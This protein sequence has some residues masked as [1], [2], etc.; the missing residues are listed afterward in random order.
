MLPSLL[1][2]AALTAPAAPVPK[3][4]VPNMTGPA[5]RI[6]AVKAEAGGTVWITAHVY[7]KQK[8]QHQFV[9]IE[10]G[11]QVVKQQ[12]VEQMT[13]NYVRKSIGDFGGKFV[14]AD[15]TSLTSEDAARRLHNGATLLITADGKPVDKGWLKAV[16]SDTIIMT[17]E[18][19]GEAHFVFGNDP[20]PLTASPRLVMLATD[21]KGDVRLP[22][23]PNAGNGNGQF[24]NEFNMRGRGGLRMA[25]ADIV[26]IDGFA[27][28][29]PVVTPTGTD[30]KKAL[31]D[32]K[33]EAYDVTGKLVQR[34]DA[35]NRLKAGGLILLAGDNRFPDANYL[36]AFREDLLVIVS[37]ELVFQ[38]GQ[39]NPFDRATLKPAAPA[40]G[41]PAVA[42]A[43]LVPLRQLNVQKIQIE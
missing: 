29:Q 41:Q 4:T 7:Q 30:G 20:Y 42:P 2:A 22:V 12:E 33:F 40:A 16:A 39:L 13:S 9:A 3:D 6:V 35:L 32:I 28:P 23:N 10:N 26:G 25:Q 43:Q 8:V 18:G 11:K 5:P 15:G 27:P 14:T 24:Y 21:D 37:S 34:S 1:V 17:A 36:Q 31:S 38:P 19:L